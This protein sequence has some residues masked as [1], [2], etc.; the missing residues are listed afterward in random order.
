MR[1]DDIQYVQDFAMCA[2]TKP[3]RH[4]LWGMA[5]SLPICQ[6]PSTD[7]ALDFIMGLPEYQKSDGDISYNLILVI[8]DRFSKVAQYKPVCDTIDAAQLASILV[9]KLILQGARMPFSIVSD[10]GRQFTL[11]F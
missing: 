2:Q 1:R 7:I 3:A 4:K 11:I 9:H 8:V 6:A 5:Q 10:R